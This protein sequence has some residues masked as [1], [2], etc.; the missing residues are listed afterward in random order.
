[1]NDDAFPVIQGEE[2]DP[3]PDFELMPPMPQL[4]KRDSEQQYFN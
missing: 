1:M 4:Q 2:T 3:G